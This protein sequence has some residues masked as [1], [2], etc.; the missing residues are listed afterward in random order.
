MI[1]A[2]TRVVKFF[3]KSPYK[4]QVKN[5]HKP[6]FFKLA[7][8]KL[9]ITK[10]A[11]PNWLKIYST[12][13]WFLTSYGNR[14][15]LRKSQGYNA[16]AVSITR[17]SRGIIVCN[18]HLKRHLPHSQ[19]Q[20]LVTPLSINPAS[21]IER[22]QPSRMTSWSI[23]NDSNI[24]ATC[25]RW[26]EKNP[27]PGK[28]CV[29]LLLVLSSPSTHPGFSSPLPPVYLVTPERVPTTHTLALLPPSQQPSFAGGC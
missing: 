15:H 13:E 20:L 24:G 1:W 26:R 18:T 7:Q 8:G 29:G 5:F 21:V 22:Q 11:C 12:I 17:T 27:H 28:R 23:P 6:F 19:C 4:F 16:Q 2:W 3:C 25:Y 10:C 9:L 14:E